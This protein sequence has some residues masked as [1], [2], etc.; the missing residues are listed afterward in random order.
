VAEFSEAMMIQ[1]SPPI[2]RD[3]AQSPIFKSESLQPRLR[4]YCTT[5]PYCTGYITNSLF[6][7]TKA[8]VSPHI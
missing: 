7:S 5:L 2:I 6:D 4:I 3:G 1:V 8:V